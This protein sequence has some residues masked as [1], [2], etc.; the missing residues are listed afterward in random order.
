MQS[1]TLTID[2]IIVGYRAV[3]ETGIGAIQFPWLAQAS[4]YSNYTLILTSADITSLHLDA[5]ATYDAKDGLV[6]GIVDPSYAC[7]FDPVTILCSNNQ[8]SNYL[9]T[10]DK[11]NAARKMYSLPS[12][13]YSDNLINFRYVPGSEFEWGMWATVY[14]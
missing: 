2:A 13:K 3:N 10:M 5:V 14:G 12:N 4:M 6:D 1:D 11:V 7:D 8:T 9:P